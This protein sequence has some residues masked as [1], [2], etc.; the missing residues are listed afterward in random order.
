[1]HRFDVEIGHS[2]FRKKEHTVAWLSIGAR[3]GII[4]VGVRG[5]LQYVPI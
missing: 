5:V 4:L 2:T 3:F 1:M